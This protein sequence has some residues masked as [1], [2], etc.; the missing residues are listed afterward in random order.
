MEGPIRIDLE[1]LHLLHE[2]QLQRFGGRAGLRDPGAVALALNHWAER[3]FDGP[4][5]DLAALAA[6]HLCA[7]ARARGFA[8]G[9]LGVAVA[10]MLVLLHVNGSPLH[11]PSEELYRLVGSVADERSPLAEEEV[12][13]WLR[14]RLRPAR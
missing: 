13:A 7:L 10:S 2:Q 9:N 14:A 4:E 11:V 12:A 6:A 3:P 1:T 8:D 5:G